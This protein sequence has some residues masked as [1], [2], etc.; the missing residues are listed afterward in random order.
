LNDNP[1]SRNP[2]RLPTGQLAFGNPNSL[3]NFSNNPFDEAVKLRPSAAWSGTQ[4]D[5]FASALGLTQAR[6]N[7]EQTLRHNFLSTIVSAGPN[8]AWDSL[9]VRAGT[10]SP[11]SNIGICTYNILG[12]SA[13]DDNL[14]GYRLRSQGARGD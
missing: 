14:M 3:P 13:P 11:H 2:H 10:T 1:Y 8:R 9:D 12:G 6:A 5:A 4:F 7:N